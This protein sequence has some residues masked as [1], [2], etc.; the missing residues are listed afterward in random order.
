MMPQ[1]CRHRDQGKEG[2]FFPGAGAALSAWN[3]MVCGNFPPRIGRL[4]QGHLLSVQSQ[5]SKIRG[6]IRMV[7]LHICRHVLTQ[8]P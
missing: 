2:A 3:R 8:L 6:Q 7:I 5:H 1:C 4:L